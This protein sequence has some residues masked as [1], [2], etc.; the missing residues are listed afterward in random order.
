ML[1]SAATKSELFG[2]L[3]PDNI[4]AALCVQKRWA[5][6]EA[7]WNEKRQKWDKVPR[8]ALHTER[9][10]ST[11][12]PANWFTFE[13]AYAAFLKH[14]NLFAG[15]GY[16]LTGSTG[17]VGIDIDG[18]LDPQTKEPNALARDILAR[19]HSYAEVSP[20]GTGLR[21]FVKG[22]TAG[23]FNDHSVG[24]EVYQGDSPRFLTVTGAQVTGTPSTLEPASPEL[25]AHLETYRKA[26]T[27]ATTTDTELPDFDGID[28]EATLARV[29]AD[30]AP[31]MV[32]ELRG[33]EPLT[34]DGSRRVAHMAICLRKAGVS[35]AGCMAVLTQCPGS[36][37]MALSHRG[38]DADRATEYLW[39]HH[40]LS[41]WV[42]PSAAHV[43]VEFEPVP[44]PSPEEEAEQ[45]AIREANKAI[46]TARE[47][48]EVKRSTTFTL[49]TVDEYCGR[50]RPLEFDVPGICPRGEMIFIGGPSGG[51][52][53]HFALHLVATLVSGGQMFGRH[54]QRKVRVAWAC[55]EGAS[56]FRARL[57]GYRKH[58]Q[59]QLDGLMLF[60]EPVV[61]TDDASVTALI[62]CLRSVGDIDYVVVDTWSKALPGCDENSS[63]DMGSAVARCIRI[64]REVGCVVVAVAHVGKD[65]TKGLRGWSGLKGAAD[66]ELMVEKVTDRNGNTS[67]Q[68]T[69]TKLKDGQG[70][71]DVFRFSVESVPIDNTTDTAGVL[72]EL[73]G[74]VPV[75][76]TVPK[77]WA[78]GVNQLAIQRAIE[79]ALALRSAKDDP[80]VS[81]DEKKLI[82]RAVALRIAMAKT[83]GQDISVKTARDG[84]QD[85]MFA[86]KGGGKL[87]TQ[88]GGRVSARGLDSLAP[89][90]SSQPDLAVDGG[91]EGL[92]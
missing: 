51:G 79:E 22:Q 84:I 39:K 19:A 62:D 43:P 27:K 68:A 65:T 54:A 71:G 37:D 2:E 77:R 47:D 78:S 82:T 16:V 4:P 58:Y 15:I 17:L 30:L 9:K 59:T 18:C 5:P 45:A 72:A 29:A 74:V 86:L 24:L 56:G 80:H 69:V 55:L 6:W 63:V 13:Q 50:V 92:L 75:A 70:E 12:S 52:K 60:K 32:K 10:L 3:K 33:L 23:D 73:S 20:S 34:G 46:S 28:G 88:S 66:A 35:Q 76:R 40:V 89:M 64:H 67:H 49:E 87:L 53:T 1:T 91:E 26:P 8:H 83:D 48:K 90:G 57:L 41:A 44:P 11:A 7:V 36:F 61:L 81:I 14:S 21:I 25:L 38:Q 42:A 31:G 85:A